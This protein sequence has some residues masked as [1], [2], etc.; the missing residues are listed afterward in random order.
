MQMRF[1]WTDSPLIQEIIAETAAQAQ[2]KVH[3][4][5]I[6]RALRVRFDSVPDG[7][8]EQIR[9]TADLQKLGDLFAWSLRCPDLD[10]FMEKL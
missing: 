1:Q 6:L 3:Q 9:A 7:I 4:E 5:D 10:A 2:A 8:A